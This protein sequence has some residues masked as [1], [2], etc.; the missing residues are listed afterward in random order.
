MTLRQVIWESAA[1]KETLVAMWL[2]VI[3]LPDRNKGC[4]LDQASQQPKNADEVVN[5]EIPVR[6]TAT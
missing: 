3:T 1:L 5:L 4:I 6:S 2:Q